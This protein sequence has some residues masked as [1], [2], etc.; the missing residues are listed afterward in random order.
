MSK[1]PNLNNLQFLEANKLINNDLISNKNEVFFVSNLTDP[2][3]KEGLHK[4]HFTGDMDQ[5]NKDLFFNQRKLMRHFET[6]VYPEPLVLLADDLEIGLVEDVNI[7]CLGV[8]FS[9]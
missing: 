2:I 8:F 7:F 3:E 5:T 1:Q 6:E 4:V 9:N